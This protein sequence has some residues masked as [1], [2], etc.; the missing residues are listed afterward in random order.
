[1]IYS[2]FKDKVERYPH[3]IAFVFEDGNS[4]TYRQADFLV[5]LIAD[6][7]VSLGVKQG[8]RVG[9][10]L[11]FE[12][13]HPAIFYALDKLNASYV[14]FDVNTPRKQLEMDVKKLNLKFFVEAATAF[15][16]IIAKYLPQHSSMTDKSK[17]HEDELI[18]F[19]TTV[20]TL[21]NTIPSLTRNDAI[22]T[23]IVSSS[24]TSDNK[25]W[26][27]IGGA[28][29]G[30]WEKTEEKQLQLKTGHGVLCTRSPAY[31][32]R[33]SEYL[34][35]LISGGCLHLISR[36]QRKDM[37]FIISYCENNIVTSLLLIAS[38][39][40]GD[41][42]EEKIK[43]LAKA[44]LVNLI[45]TGDACS[46]RLQALCIK[47]GINLFNAY[48]PTEATFGI[49]LEPVNHL[50]LT[51][52][53]GRPVVPIGFPVG[54]NIKVHLVDGKLYIESPYLINEYIDDPEKTAL[55]FPTLTINGN[56]TRVFDTGDCFE[57]K[58]GLL[59]FKGRHDTSNDSKIIGVKVDSHGIEKLIRDYSNQD[60]KLIQACVVS[61]SI[62]DRTKLVAYLVI[63][64]NFDSKKFIEYLQGWLKAEEMP[65]LMTIDA[66]PIMTVSDKI[67]RRALKERVDQ[68]FDYLL[69]RNNPKAAKRVYN[70]ELTK[71]LEQIWE[72]V[73]NIKPQSHDDDFSFQGG[74]SLYAM[75]LLKKI[76]AEID[77]KF[78]NQ[79]LF[80]LKS[81]TINN[82]YQKLDKEPTEYQEKDDQI[83]LISTLTPHRKGKPIV[84]MLPP[85]LG[86][87]DK[88]T[89][90]R[91]AESYAEDQDVNMIGL[92][93]PGLYDRSKISKT[94]DEAV[95]RY[96]NAILK[97]QPSGFYNLMGFSYGSTLAYYVALKLK[98]LGHHVTEL[99]LV[100]GFS[101]LFYQHI[102]NEQHAG[103]IKDFFRFIKET[104]SNEFYNDPIGNIDLDF[105]ITENKINQINMLIDSILAVVKNDLSRCLLDVV[106]NHLLFLL[107][108]PPPVKVRIILTR[109]YLSQPGQS[110]VSLVDEIPGL[111]K[112]HPNHEFYY[113]NNYFEH[114]T[115][116]GD[117]AACD[118]L[119]LIKHKESSQL[120]FQYSKN[121]P[122]FAR[123]MIDTQMMG[124]QAY[125]GSNQAGDYSLMICN[126]YPGCQETHKKSFL[127]NN[128][129]TQIEVFTQDGKSYITSDPKDTFY[130]ER[131]ALVARL[132]SD[133]LPNA[134]AYLKKYH[135]DTLKLPRKYSTHDNA[136]MNPAS[137]F[138]IS[139]VTLTMTWNDRLLCKFHFG[140]L[141]IN[142]S[143][144]VALKNEKFGYQLS[145]DLDSNHLTL[146]YTWPPAENFADMSFMD[147]YETCSM[148]MEEVEKRLTNIHPHIMPYVL[149]S[150][151]H[152]YGILSPSDALKQHEQLTKIIS[153]TESILEQQQ[154]RRC[155]L[156][157]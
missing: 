23:Y 123:I 48:G 109:L 5:D 27:G 145:F 40:V 14:P 89:L 16:R 73:L 79:D 131:Y 136:N 49:S 142:S 99:H 69:A 147:F 114:I 53:N 107:D 156:L 146:L 113:W 39:L 74:D 81:I 44:G 21:S 15:H 38:Q 20:R 129:C 140:A 115:R 34:R 110:F 128:L 4:Y 92:S 125:I 103:L 104:L 76:Q 141:K 144:L 80:S 95:T 78:T 130:D 85:L 152:P 126:L 98:S 51:D 62:H 143:L 28:G 25:K 45:V 150:S 31:D 96:V 90:G 102:T 139:D 1:M 124:P 101:P 10:M 70:N 22:P 66:L 112:S 18:A 119:S 50:S 3:N 134:N 94:M 12:S 135:I 111:S 91:L 13:L 57:I 2:I 122:R 32:A 8:D 157:M 138:A 9:V 71:K 61:K 36:D 24:G 87:S 11:E 151:R 108:C 29:L 154:Q 42:L 137:P 83:A 47:Y 132:T 100:D 6:R 63:S 43:R 54:E 105:L 30:Y 72:A 148:V 93:E 65:L 46:P 26:M 52:D 155:C 149:A 68:P 116:C 19:L 56:P 88:F 37:D 106:R 133:Q 67:D 75:R 97:V 86:S 82:I 59:L 17:I 127:E 64:D 41:D 117:I 58:D 7:F 33:I 120:Y 55:F 118:H 35:A 60:P 84:F 77:P 121:Q 153:E